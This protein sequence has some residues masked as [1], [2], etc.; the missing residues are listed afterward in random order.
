MSM[1]TNSINIIKYK[2][3][4]STDGITTTILLAFTGEFGQSPKYNPE[5]HHLGFFPS[6]FLLPPSKLQLRAHSHTTENQAGGLH[7]GGGGHTNG[8]REGGGCNPKGRKGGR[9]GLGGG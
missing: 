2:T 3:H 1:N 6:S 7:L 5:V 9:L 8:R 4:L